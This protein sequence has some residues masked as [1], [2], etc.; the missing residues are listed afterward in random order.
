MDISPRGSQESR[1]SCDGEITESFALA[2]DETRQSG[3]TRQRVIKS[4]KQKLKNPKALF[5]RQTENLGD[6]FGRVRGDLLDVTM[7]S[8]DAI[9]AKTDRLCTACSK[10]PFDQFGDGN[11]Y[12]SGED[13]VK[14]EV[15][16]SLDRVL[17]NRD[18]CKFCG[19]L[20]GALS[21][22][23]NDP[24]KHPA[25]QNHIQKELE[26]KTFK[27]WA[28]RATWIRR[29]IASQTIWPFGCSRAPVKLDNT[30][31]LRSNPDGKEIEEK[32]E[33]SATIIAGGSLLLLNTTIAADTDPKRLKVLGILN[34]IIPNITLADALRKKPL[35]V[36]IFVTTYGIAHPE[37]GTLVVDVY[38]C[39]RRDKAPLTRLSSFHLRVAS[40]YSVDK[41]SDQ[42]RYG[43]ILNKEKIDLS[44]CRT[45]V[46][47]CKGRHGLECSSPG[48]ARHLKNPQVSDFR[49]VDVKEEQIVRL[50]DFAE[51]DYAALSYVWGG[52]ETVKLVERNKD[53]LSSRGKLN[54]ARAGLSQTI[55]AAIE[56]TKGLG[57]R[58]LWVDSLCIVQ[59]SNDKA[60]QIGQMDRIYGNAT[61]TIVAAD[62]VNANAGIEGVSRNSKRRDG[63]LAEEV[64]PQINV[65][66]PLTHAPQIHPW[67]TRA[68]TLQE[69]LLSRRLLIFSGGYVYFHCRRGI[70]HEDMTAKDAGSGPPQIGWLSLPEDEV[71]S[72]TSTISRTPDGSSRILRS[73]VFEQYCSLIQQYTHRQMTFANDALNAIGG[74][75]KILERSRQS[76]PLS[77]SRGSTLYG[78]PDEFLDLAIL[79]QPS[80][81]ENVRLRKRVLKDKER[82]SVDDKD[83]LPSWSWAAWEALIEPEPQNQLQA[84]TES[85]AD[86]EKKIWSG[87]VRYEHPF[88][89]TTDQRGSYRKA[90]PTS[91][92]A[93]ERVKPLLRWYKLSKERPAPPA[94]SSTKV[95]IP[96]SRRASGG[97]S[98][99][100]SL[101]PHTPPRSSQNAARSKSPQSSGRMRL[102]PVNGTGIGLALDTTETPR[103]W[104]QIFGNALIQS[105]LPTGPKPE[106]PDLPADILQQL[107]SRHLVFKT[108]T[109][110][111]SLGKTVLR[112]ETMWRST[113]EGLVPDHELNIYETEILDSCSR[114]VGRV[115]PH[116]H[117]KELDQS[118]CNFIVLS[119]S[120]YFGDEER[121]D[122][123]G[124]SLYNVM[125]V[126][127]DADRPW[128]ASRA[129][130]G[131]VYKRAWEEAG[132][133][134]K[135][136]VLG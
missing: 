85:H 71:A 122:V 17:Q 115:I 83:Q 105:R 33:S 95:T 91:E 109:A 102:T 31:P 6:V 8:R 57:I 42:L 18:W 100:T 72:A 113:E 28:A 7:S 15:I 23:E 77:K 67:D 36:W 50:G 13:D 99:Q 4:F 68:W 101:R 37:A 44:I 26:G 120:Q 86:E 24:L 49:L 129:A 121:V 1:R 66:I 58:Y 40:G 116:D 9:G 84:H 76:N 103:D 92:D 47:H 90:I 110:R 73:P 128:L 19:L 38:G 118:L 117:L 3:S 136:F 98:L 69:K 107:D 132:P 135:I 81:G 108:L 48:W 74:L 134:E 64:K 124:Y 93:E 97:L 119:E 94:T 43:R 41:E 55:R 11:E 82:V 35:P 63:Q 22:E 2:S 88:R 46:E 80:D 52:F 53:E 39:G 27:E 126:D 123:Q 75:M 70:S 29:H 54:L 34:G 60:R 96:W 51:C 21:V 104:S 78:L 5:S 133:T 112:T 127:Y 114:V 56:V 61:V 10:I 106:I 45:W 130:I 131:K 30:N 111:L 79:W 59:D 12:G 14:S 125:M 20:V 25:V 62:G 87:G 32:D 16:T 89:V 65:L